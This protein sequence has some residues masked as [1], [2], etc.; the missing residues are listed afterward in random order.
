MHIIYSNIRFATPHVAVHGVV[1]A[2]CKNSDQPHHV[3]RVMRPPRLVTPCI[4]R[5]KLA[6][7]GP[8]A[9]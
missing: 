5:N 1:M 2:S 8:A 4:I 3:L 9:K 6:I 7:T